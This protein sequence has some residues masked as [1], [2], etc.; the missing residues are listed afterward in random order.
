MTSAWSQSQYWSTCKWLGGRR[1]AGGAFGSRAGKMSTPPR[2]VNPSL[3][4]NKTCPPKEENLSS[5]G[6]SVMP[7]LWIVLTYVCCPRT[8]LNK[9]KVYG[10]NVWIILQWLLF[11][12][13]WPRADGLLYKERYNWCK[14]NCLCVKCTKGTESQKRWKS[15]QIVMNFDKENIGKYLH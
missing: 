10:R 15:R 9:T 2:N 3:W 5:S 4:Q 11:V 7:W 6:C 13:V 12:S 14:N 8:S 1:E